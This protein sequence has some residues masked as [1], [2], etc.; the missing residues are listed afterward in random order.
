[1]ANNAFMQYVYNRTEEILTNDPEYKQLQSDSVAAEK[2]GD[3]D[4]LQEINCRLEARA[5]ELCYMTGF[6]DAMAIMNNNM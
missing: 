4:S 1:M 5:E 6:R 3:T 2:A